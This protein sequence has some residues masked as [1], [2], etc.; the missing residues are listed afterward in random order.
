M[1]VRKS[2][3]LPLAITMLLCIFAVP[4]AAVIA[5]D[6]VESVAPAYAPVPIPFDEYSTRIWDTLLDA[7]NYYGHDFTYIP[8]N[9]YYGGSTYNYFYI[10]ES[11]AKVYLYVK[12]DDDDGL[13]PFVIPGYESEMG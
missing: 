6:P 10:M 1:C 13:D 5:Q 12:Y 2:I 4:V 3:C 9:H 11:G 7:K 8:C